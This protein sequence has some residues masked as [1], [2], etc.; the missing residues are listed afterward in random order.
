[1]SPDIPTEA[2]LILG[3]QQKSHIQIK[4]GNISMIQNLYYASTLLSLE[5]EEVEIFL[6]CSSDIKG[7]GI[8][9]S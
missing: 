1:M 4:C 3:P 9:V 2:G 5:W 8:Y 7:N 6:L